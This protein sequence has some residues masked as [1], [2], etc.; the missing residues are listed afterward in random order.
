ML[1]SF[2]HRR[3]ER[4][5]DF[6]CPSVLPSLGGCPASCPDTYRLTH[7]HR[8]VRNWA[9]M[10]IGCLP[11]LRNIFFRLMKNFPNAC[12]L[13]SRARCARAMLRARCSYAECERMLSF[14]AKPALARELATPAG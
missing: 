12:L 8:H 2:R 7:D 4:R 10:Q 1:G 13:L 14:S 9:R 3:R 5:D 6:K 11:P